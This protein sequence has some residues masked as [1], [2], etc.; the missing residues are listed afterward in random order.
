MTSGV[1]EIRGHSLVPPLHIGAARTCRPPWGEGRSCTD[2]E[3]AC[4]Q[5]PDAVPPS[6]LPHVPFVLPG[7]RGFFVMPVVWCSQEDDIRGFVRQEM[8]QHCGE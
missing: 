2:S 7:V 3:C 5:H 6:S 4:P 8:S 1:P